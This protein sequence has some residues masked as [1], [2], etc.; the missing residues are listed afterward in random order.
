MLPHNPHNPMAYQHNMTAIPMCMTCISPTALDFRCHTWLSPWKHPPM[1]LLIQVLRWA[2]K[3]RFT[4]RF[5]RVCR[6]FLDHSRSE[7]P[8]LRGILVSGLRR[9]Q[10]ISQLTFIEPHRGF[11]CHV[12]YWCANACTQTGIQ[13]PSPTEFSA[14]LSAVEADL[15]YSSPGT[16]A[17]PYS[18][19]LLYL[20]TLQEM[21]ILPGLWVTDRAAPVH[22]SGLM[23]LWTVCLRSSPEYLLPYLQGTHKRNW[24]EQLSFLLHAGHTRVPHGTGRHVRNAVTKWQLSGA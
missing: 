16:S 6:D 24:V 21:G 17:A 11:P 3:L 15:A 22:I 19:S 1:Q 8:A 13:H 20:Q 7:W 12:T 18:R 14:A 5:R 9:V 23:K 4:S 2:T 10:L